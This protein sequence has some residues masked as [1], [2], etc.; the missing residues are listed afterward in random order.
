MKVFCVGNVSYDI[1]YQVDS[2]PEENTKNRLNNKV[3]CGGGPASTA[4][5]LLGKWGLDVHFAGVIGN[6]NHGD[7][8]KKELETVNVNTKYLEVSNDIETTTSFILANKENGSRTVYTYKPEDMKLKDF[9]LDFIPDVLYFD[10]QEIEISNKLL[11]SY[12]DAI[13]IIDAGR[14]KKEIIDLCHR[15]NYI[16]CSLQFACEVTNIEV[17][18]SDFNTLINL[19]TKMK[20]IFKKDV[21]ITLEARGCLANINNQIQIIPSISVK[22]IDSTGAGDI[23]H[24]AFTYGLVKKFDIANII[25]VANI[26]GAISVTRL[27]GRY[28][29][30]ELQEVVNVY[31]ETK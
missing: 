17:D 7:L 24:G 18:F 20:E 23:F 13:S 26:T 15:V 21:Y 11:D 22:A 30:P 9:E 25:R 16:V 29:V 28:S 1:T 14:S 6:D 19:Y 8:I 27:G 5:Y 3:E 10:G 31:N 2:F 4:A 12:P